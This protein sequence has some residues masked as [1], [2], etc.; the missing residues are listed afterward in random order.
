MQQASNPNEDTLFDKMSSDTHKSHLEK[1]RCFM[2][3]ILTE[4]GTSNRCN[5]FDIGNC[6]ELEFAEFIR[7]LG[8]DV[9]ELPNE[10]RVDLNIHHYGR[11][12]IKYSSS[13]DIT[14]HNSNSC[15]NK[16]TNMVDLILITKEQIW[17][18]KKDA[19]PYYNVLLDQ[20][21]VNK[22][23]SLKLKRKLLSAL[24]HSKYPFVM[25]FRLDVSSCKHRHCYKTFHNAAKTEYEQSLQ[26]SLQNTESSSSK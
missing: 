17:L 3:F 25:H 4:Y 24:T 13:G 12:S 2:E 23:D 20:Y 8:F 5:R 26:Q 15:I 14:L 6:I 11:L 22:G 18:I 10:K 9:D 21:L 19:L 1:S 7:L 16:D